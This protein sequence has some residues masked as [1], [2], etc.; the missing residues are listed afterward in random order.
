MN[1]LAEQIIIDILKQ[2]M[3]LENERIWVR[4][5]NRKIGY[6]TGIY[7]TA[8]MVDETILSAIKYT[9]EYEIP[10]IPPATDPTIGLR[11]VTQ[12][13]SRENVQIDIFSRDN[14]AILRRWEIVAAMNSYYSSQKQEENTFKIFRTPSNFVNTSG[15]EGGSNI[16]RYSIVMA[17]HVWYNKTNELP[18]YDYYDDFK[19]R[20]D[21]ANTIDQDNGLIEFRIKDNE[22]IPYNSE[23]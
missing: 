11:Q 23:E 13:V 1:S 5:Q 14:S 2:E 7:V 19:T 15:A 9:E 17:C 10:P 8:G 20:V 6:D 3:G 21:D 16:N 4:D 18:T 12:V 22:F